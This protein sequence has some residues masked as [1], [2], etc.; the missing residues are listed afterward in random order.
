MPHRMAGRPAKP[1]RKS[2]T[3]RMPVDLHARASMAAEA[4]KR[5]VNDVMVEGIERYVS[6]L[7]GGPVAEGGTTADPI[8]PQDIMRRAVEAA[9]PNG[10]AYWITERLKWGMRIDDLVDAAID[11]GARSLTQSPAAALGAG[12]A[13]AG[14]APPP[15]ASADTPPRAQK[16]QP[17]ATENATADTEA[18]VEVEAPSA[19][20]PV[21]EPEPEPEPDPPWIQTAKSFAAARAAEREAHPSAVARL[22]RLLGR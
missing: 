2:H 6:A 12:P 19:P 8:I 4:A 14:Q 21:P 16:L 11:S 13:Q 22:R 9:G 10:A 1:N 20:D 5:P 7:E 18:A 15:T 3:I 17:P